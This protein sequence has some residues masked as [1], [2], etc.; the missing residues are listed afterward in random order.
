MI[1][2]LWTV[3]SV[4]ALANLMALA[5]F[6]VWL[7]A[8]DRLSRSRIQEVRE[9][10]R[11]PVTAQ[12]TP[13]PGDAEGGEQAADDHPKTGAPVT[14]EQRLAI[15]REYD[16]VARQRY[17]RVQR[18]TEDLI[19]TLAEERR[20]LE[21]REA[22]FQEERAAWESER[23]RIEE[24]EG[25]EQ[26]QKAL[27]VYISLKP[28]QAKDMLAALIA[29]GELPQVVSYLDAMPDRNSAKIIEEFHAQ[30]PALAA[31]LLERLRTHGFAA[32]VP[33]EP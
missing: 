23:K 13:A 9:L 29:K 15:I 21:A 28:S 7:G 27:G 12:Q 11:S 20:A 4:L 14:A 26:F 19:S 22:R 8:T 16:E 17:Q 3:I 6:F 32:V 24:L 31:D 2:S 30:D 33:E 10:F 18:E 25:S 5:A 1:K